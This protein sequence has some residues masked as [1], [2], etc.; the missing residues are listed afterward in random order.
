[1]KS[2]FF[3]MNDEEIQAIINH[4]MCIIS[5]DSEWNG[6]MPDL[7]KGNDP[8]EKRFKNISVDDIKKSHETSSS[9]QHTISKQKCSCDVKNLFTF[10]CKC[11][12][13]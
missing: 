1:M 9:S 12:G 7:P 8:L 3:K 4:S 6:G 11:G 2:Q 5:Y 10:G 13:F